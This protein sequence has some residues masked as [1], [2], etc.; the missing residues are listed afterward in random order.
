MPAYQYSQTNSY[1]KEYRAKLLIHPEY[2][3]LRMRIR[4]YRAR[5]AVVLLTCYLSFL[6]VVVSFPHVLLQPVSAQNPTPWLIP[7]AITLILLQFL[8]TGIYVKQMNTVFDEEL[9]R[10]RQEVEVSVDG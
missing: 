9:E 3:R 7:V 5:V 1:Q 4:Q 8:V 10:I 6:F 2:Q